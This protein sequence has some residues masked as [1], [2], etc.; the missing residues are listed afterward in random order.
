MPRG[1]CMIVSAPSGGG[2]STLIREMLQRFDN[3]RH[4]ISYTTR[5]PRLDEGDKNDYHFIDEAAFLQMQA[6]DEFLEWAEVHGR[7]Y[8]TSRND[9][10]TLLAHGYDVIMDIDIQGAMQ[11][12][13]QLADAVYVFVMPPS[14]EIL[15]QRLRDR[16]SETL[17]ALER[18]LSNA[19]QEIP[20]Y[21]RYDYVVIND[22][23]ETAIDRLRSILIAEHL[24]TKRRAVHEQA[25]LCMKE[26][27]R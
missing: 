25:M 12:K 16:R 3:L 1:I 17:A 10:D 6:A 5:T 18:R 20:W 4:S 22:D 9:L 26:T 24:S 15:E 7:L 11:A 14:M 8:G 23:L 21:D 2:K 13:E 27:K 19:L